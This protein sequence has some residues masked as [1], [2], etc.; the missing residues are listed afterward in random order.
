MFYGMA[1]WAQYLKIISSIVEAVSI[2]VMYNKD[3][4]HR[5]EPTS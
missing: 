3:C 2:F 4:W 5:I 1:I